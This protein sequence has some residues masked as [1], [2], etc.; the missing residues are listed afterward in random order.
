[1]RILCSLVLPLILLGCQPP[2]PTAEPVDVEA[3]LEA[4]AEQGRRFSQAYMDGDVEALM[5]IYT[6]DAV[7]FPERTEYM[8]GDDAL[9]RYWTLSE[10]QRII[11]HQLMP[12]EVEVE[13]DMAS[14]FGYYEVRG[15]RNGEAWGP[16]RGKYLVVWKKGTDGMWRMHLDMWNQ[17]P[18]PASGNSGD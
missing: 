8:R 9:R 5:A 15:E 17:A 1:M 18:Q 10:G 14:D 4:I 2:P 7:I 3:E 13:G 12:V 6:D 16:T 11:H